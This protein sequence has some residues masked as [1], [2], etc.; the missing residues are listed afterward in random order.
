MILIRVF[1]SWYWLNE[2]D[3]DVKGVR[4]VADD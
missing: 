1:G 3:M 2:V 4:K